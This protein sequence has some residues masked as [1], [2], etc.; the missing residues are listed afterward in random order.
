MFGDVELGGINIIQGFS[1]TALMLPTAG[2]AGILGKRFF[3]CFD[4]V[5]LD[6]GERPGT[7]TFHQV[8]PNPP[9]PFGCATLLLFINPM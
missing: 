1:A 8:G 3:D 2:L 9:K 7:A 5:S 4:A 6:W